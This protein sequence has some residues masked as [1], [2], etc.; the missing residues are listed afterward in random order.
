MLDAA[1]GGGALFLADDAD[2]LAAETAEA[3]H[4]RLV[5]AELAVARHRREF[6][7][8]RIDEIG[9]VRPLRMTRHQR[10]LPRRQTGIEVGQRLRRLVLDPRDLVADI[11]AGRGKR[12]QLVDLGLEFGDGF[13]EVEIAAHLIRHQGNI[14]NNAVG[15]EA[16]SDSP[17]KA[18]IFNDLA[19]ISTAGSLIAKRT[20]STAAGGRRLFRG[21]WRR[22][23]RQAVSS[24]VATG[25]REENAS[26]EMWAPD[27]VYFSASGCR[28]R[29]RLFSR[30]S[31]TWV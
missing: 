18:R 8:Q 5:L 25:S 21:R 29:T 6:G 7:D 26:D 19:W 4:Q 24:E 11:A 1:L 17:Q 31:T 23:S 20:P 22:K 16:V 9:E 28:S 13:F 30:S 14:G 2:A 15:R 3:A 27:A 10:L 12:A